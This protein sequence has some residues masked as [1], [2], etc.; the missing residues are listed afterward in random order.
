VTL[1]S[2]SHAERSNRE[3]EDERITFFWVT[4]RDRPQRTQT[5]TDQNKDNSHFFRFS[6]LNSGGVSSLLWLSLEGLTG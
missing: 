3:R 5:N 4:Q 6:G 1:N 2:R